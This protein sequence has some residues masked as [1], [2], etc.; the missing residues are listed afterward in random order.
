MEKIGLKNVG[1]VHRNLPMP[2]LVEMAVARGEGYLA[3]NGALVVHTGKFSGR[4][5]RDK[6]TVDQAPSTQ[7]IWWGPINQKIS[8]ENWK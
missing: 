3:P 1:R 6:F 7:N 4:S 8:V 5:P 2:A